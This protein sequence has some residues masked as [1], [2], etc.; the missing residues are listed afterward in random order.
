MPPEAVRS[1]VNENCKHHSKYGPSERASR[2]APEEFLCQ[3]RVG[4]QTLRVQR[5]LAKRKLR[6]ADGNEVPFV[7]ASQYSLLHLASDRLAF[8][9]EFTLED[10]FYL[11]LL[12]KAFMIMTNYPEPHAIPHRVRAQVTVGHADNHALRVPL[13]TS[14]QQAP[15][16]R[17]LIVRTGACL[18]QA[19]P[20]ELRDSP[21]HD[22]DIRR[23]NVELP[24]LKLVVDSAGR[25]M[26]ILPIGESNPNN[27]RQ[28]KEPWM[29]R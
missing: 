10:V 21:R 8:L 26:R 2:Y 20:A 22:V 23:A 5:G 25:T 6:G 15:L 27:D 9:S 28:C 11:I 7:T 14:E 18:I 17:W 16:M 29:A 1:N 12:W 13:L 4:V 3:I 19:R 24:Q